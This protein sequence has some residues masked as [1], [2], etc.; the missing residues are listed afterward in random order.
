MQCTATILSRRLRIILQELGLDYRE[1][2]TLSSLHP[3]QR[4]VVMALLE[5][6][7]KQ[8]QA[9]TKSLEARRSES[10][11]KS[12][13]HRRV[14]NLPTP[15]AGHGL[16]AFKMRNTILTQSQFESKLSFG[17]GEIQKD[18]GPE[19][20]RKYIMNIHEQNTHRTH[21]RNTLGTRTPIEGN[22]HSIQAVTKQWTR[23]ITQADDGRELGVKSDVSVQLFDS[24]EI[25]RISQNPDIDVRGK[26]R[27]VL[28]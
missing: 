25:V 7:R 20:E 28:Q 10:V 17:S 8:T 18:P 3:S 22:T 15:A 9:F 11:W 14:L 4:S 16:R 26:V 19:M 23:S 6:D 2:N 12:A 21:D 24:E 27:S 1:I 13:S 5:I